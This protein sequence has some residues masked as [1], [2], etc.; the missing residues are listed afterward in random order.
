MM[1]VALKCKKLKVS[2]KWQMTKLPT[3]LQRVQDRAG[4]QDN[5]G[6]TEGGRGGRNVG[7]LTLLPT[8][9][10]ATSIATLQ[11]TDPQE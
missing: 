3:Q 8:V 4:R 1:P 5:V 2:H 7:I 6:Q 10:K 9:F 11:N